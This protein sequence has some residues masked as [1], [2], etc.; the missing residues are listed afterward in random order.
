MISTGWLVALW[1][2]IV[3]PD[4]PLQK[5]HQPPFQEGEMVRFEV[6]AFGIKGGEGTAILTKSRPPR[7]EAALSAALPDRDLW[8]IKGR[9]VISAPISWF[10]KLDDT[11]QTWL[12]PDSLLPHRRELRIKESS[13]RAF[14]RILFDHGKN[15]AHFYR[16]RTFYRGNPAREKVTERTSYLFPQTFDAIALFKYLRCVRVQPGDALRL[17]VFEDEKNRAVLIQ[18]IGFETL[19]TIF[20]EIE[21]IR[22]DI[23]VLPEG[24]L[25]K[26]RPFRGWVSRD[27]R[28]VPLK[29]VVDLRYAGLKGE[30]RGYRRHF[31]APIQGELDPS[32]VE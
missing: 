4:P 20:G 22:A 15:T 8:H 12:L 26:G 32:F 2:S 18:V 21:A 24:K 29:F 13:E 10:Y 25:V 5:C 27:S 6:S 19:S 3:S 31:S 28:R 14:R 16:D 23:T 11:L 9:G 30:L 7:P 17:T 1:L